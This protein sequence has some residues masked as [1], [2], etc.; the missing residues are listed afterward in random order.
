MSS[1]MKALRVHAI[2]IPFEP[3][4]IVGRLPKSVRRRWQIWDLVRGSK[5]DRE[6]VLFRC[7]FELVGEAGIEPATSS[8]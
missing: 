3:V 7:F 2:V 4:R 8:L 6:E 1:G 5:R